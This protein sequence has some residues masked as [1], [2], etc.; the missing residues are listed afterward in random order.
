MIESSGN[1]EEHLQAEGQ[2]VAST[3]GISMWPMLRHRR[4]MIVLSSFEGDLKKYDVPLYRLPSGKLVLH[5]ILQVRDDHY[6]IRGDN[7][8]RKEHVPK[9]WVVAV[10]KSFYRS[11]KY[12]D[13]EKSKV[14][15]V[16]VR[17]NIWSFPLRY[18]WKRRIRP[19]LAKIK[20]TVFPVR[21][22]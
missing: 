16:Y 3:S 17:C 12:Y 21:T 1:I 13:C 6:V 5:R 2:V 9:E 14:Y 22:D 18:L 19:I 8:L 7:L 11:G 4:D 10:L 15:K 20:H